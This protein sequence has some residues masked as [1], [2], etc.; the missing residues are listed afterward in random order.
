MK[1]KEQTMQ[2]TKTAK[3]I[4]KDSSVQGFGR[5]SFLSRLLAI[6]TLT[7]AISSNAFGICNEY[8]CL[9][10]RASAGGW[11]GLDSGTN[12]KITSYGWLVGAYARITDDKE[13]LQVLTDVKIGLG[14]SNLSGNAFRL[15]GNKMEDLFY[16]LPIKAGFNVANQRMPFFINL[17]YEAEKY[18]R[19][20]EQGNGFKLQTR[21]IGAEIDGKFPLGKVSLEYAFG[22]KWIFDSYYN[23]SQTYANRAEIKD[24][25]YG[26]N[27]SIGI[28]MPII[29]RA[30]FFIKVSGR[31]SY[32]GQSELL[33]H[34]SGAGQ[35]GAI[36]NVQYPASNNI[37]AMLEIGFGF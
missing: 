34:T 12:A 37:L 14:D 11:Y 23:I 24:S 1:I 10:I 7:C 5:K 36:V 25:G 32:I 18:R 15:Y 27:G 4:S 16:I 21:G 2:T 31:Y 30:L 29:D 20:Y 3:S 28:S 17:L 19:D 22:A 9:N 13:R 35:T 8:L 26:L 33:L 6:C